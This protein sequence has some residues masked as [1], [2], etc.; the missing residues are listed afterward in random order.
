MY[1]CIIPRIWMCF[2]LDHTQP[3]IHRR[4]DRFRFR[5]AKTAACLACLAEP[6]DTIP[7]TSRR[8]VLSD[9]RNTKGDHC[10]HYVH[11]AFTTRHKASSLI[12]IVLQQGRYGVGILESG[13]QRL[14]KVSLRP[15]SSGHQ[16]GSIF[17]VVITER[18]D[19]HGYLILLH[20]LA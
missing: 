18:N 14:I 1:H 3:L 4:Y 12:S 11:E 8:D 7:Q 6:T 20:S 10:Y 16:H 13:R 19:L 2:D 9:V 5:S 15:L 17:N